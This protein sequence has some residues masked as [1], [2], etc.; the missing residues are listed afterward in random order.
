MSPTY[1]VHPEFGYFCP[2]PRARRELRVAVVSI[3][4]GM[5]IGAAIVT[6]GAGH[7]VET[8]G[9]SSNAHLKSS[10]SDPLLPGSGG[11]SSQFKDADRAKTDPVAAIKPYPM[12]MVRVSSSKVASA[13]A[14]VPLVRTAQP[15][16]SPSAGP[17]SHENEEA[18]VSAA[19]SPAARR[20]A[21]AAEPAILKTKK[22]PSAMHARRHWDDA[23][24]NVRWQSWGERAYAEER[25]WRG[26]YRN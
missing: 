21:A 23:N 6:V 1:Y 15:E 25:S 10:S 18:S 13:L 24:E 17:T 4:F 9:V 5:V 7:A 19:A 20:V 8:G 3:L 2:G 16:P 22:R 26:A 12:R 14:G 11:P